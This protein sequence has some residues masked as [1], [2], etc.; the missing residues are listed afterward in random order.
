MTT[1][2]RPNLD[3]LR[4]ALPTDAL[5]RER[6]FFTPEDITYRAEDDNGEESREFVGHALL[7]D[8]VT[9][10]RS[11]FGDWDEQIARG[12]TAKT[13]KEADVRFLINHDPNLLLARSKAGAG[14]LKLREDDKGLLN[15]A[16]LPKRSFADDL[17]DMLRTGDI[18]QMSFAFSVVKEEW[19]ER[20]DDVPL[21]TIKEV[22]LYDTSVVTYPA[23]EDT[24]AALRTEQVEQMI[25]RG[26]LDPDELRQFLSSLEETTEPSEDTPTPEPA[27]A[28]R[29]RLT[30]C[31]RSMDALAKFH[32][33]PA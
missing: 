16:T 9:R 27:P 7:F 24:D 32:G 12:A 15:E 18:S 1:K 6:R 21:R 10:I 22:K 26:A 25:R 5:G 30:R 4:N 17:V 13:I 19:Q 31:D 14:T 11:W 33:L 29:S 23:Y 20:E 28:T 3:E 2:T 8:N